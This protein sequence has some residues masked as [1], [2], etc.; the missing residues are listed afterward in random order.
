M[1]STTL[2]SVC[3]YCSCPQPERLL[4]DQ[5]TWLAGLVHALTEAPPSAAAPP[6]V[7]DGNK[8]VRVECLQESPPHMQG[9]DGG[10]RVEQ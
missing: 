4:A 5:C 8:D 7:L 3:S 10:V 9:E 2:V 1:L 6:M